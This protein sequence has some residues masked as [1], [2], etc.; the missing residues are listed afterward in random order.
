MITKVGED[1]FGRFLAS[2]LSREKVDISQV[3][4]CPQKTGLAFVFLSGSGERSF[5][6]Y[7]DGSA[8]FMIEESDIDPSYF[9]N[10]KI[11]HFSSAPLLAE[12]TSRA[13]F[14]A[15]KIAKESG[16]KI[17]FDPNLRKGHPIDERRM[18]RGIDASD[19]LMLTAEEARLLMRERKYR[20]A[21]MAL[22]SNSE[23]VGIKLGSRGCYILDR[24]GEFLVPAFR[25]K[26]VDTTGAGDGWDAGFIYGILK[27]WELQ[28]IGK[29]ANAVGALVCTKKGAMT[30][31]PSRREVLEFMESTK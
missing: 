14:R 27:G 24:S 17:S 5:L 1:A 4:F 3:K 12:K 11:F 13:L 2:V 10:A 30:A 31:L 15:I 9:S 22:L 29:F 18:K 26:P 20:E 21:A 6:F 25:V 28:R 16:A 23:I 8:D 7:R 19:Y